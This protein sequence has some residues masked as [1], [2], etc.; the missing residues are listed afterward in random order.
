MKITRQIL[1][2]PP[3]IST[4]WD[5]ISS[6][7]ILQDSVTLAKTLVISLKNST[8][9]SIPHLTD[10]LLQDIF[11][12]HEESMEKQTPAPTPQFKNQHPFSNGNSN[13]LTFGLPLNLSDVESMEGLGNFF[14]HSIEQAQSPDLPP[15][16][17]QKITSVS[18]MMGLDKHAEQLPKAE[19]HCNCPHCQIARALH[20]TPA[21]ENSSIKQEEEIVSDADLT[22]RD[23]DIKEIG[24]NLYEVTSPLEPTQR[25]QVFLDTPIGCTCGEKNCEHIKAVLSS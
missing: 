15:E 14:Q 21:K 4:A 1:S 12:M 16:M 13:V 8:T 18:K 6:L 10:T 23:W 3:Y 2:I 9:V 20:Q 19:P 24:K 7:H 25:Y 22:F 17:L 5:N 11:K